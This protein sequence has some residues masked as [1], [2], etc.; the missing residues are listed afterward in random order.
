MVSR[1][2]P[3]TKRPLQTR[4][5]SDSVPKVLNLAIEVQ[6]VGSLCKRHVVTAFTASTACKQSVSGSFHPPRG[7]LFTFPSRYLFS[8][9]LLGVFSLA[10]WCRRF[11]RGFHR[12]PLTQDT[13]HFVSFSDTGL[14][15]STVVFPNTFSFS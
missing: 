5:R 12:S 15:P 2:P 6:L 13:E 4:F 9:G 11:Q 7:V 1:L 3:I 8:I 14:S 10:G